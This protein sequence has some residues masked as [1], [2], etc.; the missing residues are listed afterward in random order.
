MQQ[1]ISINRKHDVDWSN[2][3]LSYRD[4]KPLF[5]V[6]LTFLR[7]SGTLLFMNSLHRT[8]SSMSSDCMVR[9]GT[10]Q[11]PKQVLMNNPMKML[12]LI[13]SAILL[14]FCSGCVT[15]PTIDCRKTD[16]PK[17]AACSIVTHPWM[18]HIV[19]SNNAQ[20]VA[21]MTLEKDTAIL[22]EP[23]KYTIR[24]ILHRPPADSMDAYTFNAA[25]NNFL[26]VIKSAE[27]LKKEWD[28]ISKWYEI[29][30]VLNTYPGKNYQLLPCADQTGKMWILTVK[31]R[32]FSFGKG[33]QE[34]GSESGHVMDSPS[35][36]K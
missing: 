21:D 32:L 2:S 33:A 20:V 36:G 17:E 18:Q 12:N 13:V 6:I 34:P 14:M 24:A 15:I 26:E 27:T 11:T 19:I 8:G 25:N 31:D 35:F 5:A 3:P 9:C 1:G 28:A 23:G 22:I 10:A 7:G 16:L 30:C 4:A 29:S